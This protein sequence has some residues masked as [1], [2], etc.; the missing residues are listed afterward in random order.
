MHTY[1]RGSI[2]RLENAIACFISVAVVVV[3]DCTLFYVYSREGPSKLH[4]FDVYSRE[5]HFKLHYVDVY[6]RG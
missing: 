1:N 2:P 6:S 5:G 4:T 3:L